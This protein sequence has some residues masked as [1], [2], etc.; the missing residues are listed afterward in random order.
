MF[1]LFVLKIL[2]AVVLILGIPLGSAAAMIYLLVQ[3][4]NWKKG[5]QI[6]R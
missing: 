6:R 5:E 4:N 1:I 3:K 2:L